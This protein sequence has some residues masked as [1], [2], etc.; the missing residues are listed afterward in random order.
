MAQN[1]VEAAKK[2]LALYEAGYDPHDIAVEKAL[3]ALEVAEVNL[4]LAEEKLAIA[5]TNLEAK[6]AAYDT[7]IELYLTEDS[8][9]L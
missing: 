4:T 7:V 3:L 5:E 1:E 2:V 6:K 9:D 8:S